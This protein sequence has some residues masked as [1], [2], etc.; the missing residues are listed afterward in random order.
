MNIVAQWTLDA[1][2]QDNPAAF[3]VYS[4]LLER[5]FERTP[6]PFSE[7]WYGD[8]YRQWSADP[9][10]LANSLVA[11]AA[12]EGDGSRKLWSL[13]ARAADEEISES[14]RLHAIDESRHAKLYLRMLDLAFPGAAEGELRDELAAL[15]PG[16]GPH[17][18]P[19]R[20]PASP[21]E[22]VL[23]EL[24]QMNI[25][26]IRTRVH[27]MLMRPVITLH[28][29]PENLPRLTR[30]LDSILADET[31]HIAYTA[32]L[33]ERTF[34]TAGGFI[35]ATMSGRCDEF[36]ELTR[37]EVGGEPVYD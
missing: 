33:I 12:K 14:V 25:G 11:N 13:V 23:D 5:T 31:K 19:E 15:S 34:S 37:T 36:N 30:I 27:Q 3:P 2:R 24:I 18:F 21:E 10:W 7:R 4:R 8:R 28:C 9:L 16:Y 20:Q 35:E 1:I 17:D 26:E 6:P 32:R 22:W 29:P